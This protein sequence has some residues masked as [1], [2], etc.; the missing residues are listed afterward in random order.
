MRPPRR[1]IRCKIC[2]G[3]ASL[4]G[5]VDFNKNCGEAQGTYLELTGVPV[6]YHRCQQCGFVFTEGMD[7]WTFDDFRTHIYNAGYAQVDPDAETRR[8][9][10]QV[11]AVLDMARAF[12]VKHILDYGG[13]NGLLARKLAE[14]GLAAKTWDPVAD[15][16]APPAPPHSF[17]L[18]TA[19]EVLEHT[20]MP[21]ETCAQALSFLR[22]RGP[23]LFSTLINDHARSQGCDWWYLAP[24]NGHI[25]LYSRDSLG[26]LFKQFG[27][28]VEH[29]SAGM[30]LAHRGNVRIART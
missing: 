23:L 10:G 18:V 19:F 5:V 28:T 22:D 16:T 11:A 6:Y 7:D 30:H 4:F 29:L 2:D 1:T 17:D 3:T 15:R 25:S 21:R 12:G 26:I 9:T 13:G 27:Y 8:P 24:R 14:H 20:P